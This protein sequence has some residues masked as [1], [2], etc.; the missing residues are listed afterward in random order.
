MTNSTPIEFKRGAVE[1]VECLK[2]GWNLIKDQYWLFVGMSFVGLM[3]AN[4]VPFGILLGPMMCGIYLALFRM[5]RKQPVQFGDLFK[6]F[7]Y[8][9][10]SVIATLF[11]MVPII[12]IL[13]TFYIAIALGMFLVLPSSGDRSDP[14][15]VII[16]FSILIL[17][18]IGMMLV[19][20]LV[21]IL[22][23][24]AYPLIVDRRLSGI[25]AI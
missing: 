11:H 9:G 23:A 17:G 5:Q 7:D 22:F 15:G 2:Q 6:G 10:E 3:I 4:F 25:E 13:A 8:F 1:P 12:L 18:G 14:T 19:I 16:F 20:V 24:F 21:S